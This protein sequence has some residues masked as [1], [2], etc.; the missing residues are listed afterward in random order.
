VIDLHLHTTASDGRLTPTALVALAARAGLRVVS[1]TDHDTVAGLAEA[2]EAAGA[3]GVRLVNGIEMTAV[4]A[5]RDVHVLGYFFDPENP[6]LS[7]FLHTQRLAR[8]D[9]VRE[10]AHRL[11]ALHC[12]IDV[13]A[14]LAATPTASGRSVGRPLVADALVA[15]GHAVNRRDA[16]DRWLGQGC[17]AFV[18]RCG[19]DVRA[20]V[21]AIANAGGVASLAHPGLLGTDERIPGYATSG[22]SAIEARHRDHSP[23]DEAR[24]RGLAR[25]LGLAVSGGSDFH[26][27]HE[28]RD[29]SL[30]APG[31]VRLAE[32]DFAGL[33][34]RR[35]ARPPSAAP[36]GKATPRA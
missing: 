15:A 24:Y 16:F 22:L 25:A 17:P 26:G 31:S 13:E 7:R 28:S 30:A 2:R 12:D 1:V 10:I 8:I 27:E 32:E 18:P 36:I 20:V 5:G 35:P 33:E 23:A 14:L 29:G 34:A 11:H 6:E 9:R 3:H 21:E 4:D 19:P